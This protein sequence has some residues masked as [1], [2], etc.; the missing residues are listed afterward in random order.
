MNKISRN[1]A[2]FIGL[3]LALFGYL[4]IVVGQNISFL[5][6][7]FTEQNLTILGLLGIWILTTLILALLKTGERKPFA[8]IGFKTSTMKEIIL[9][10]VIGIVLSLSVPMLTWLVSQILPAAPPDGSVTDVA[11][12][13]SWLLLLISILTAGITEEIIFRG[14]VLERLFEKTGKWW[15]AIVVSMTAFVLPHLFTWNMV[16]L[17]AVVI[18]LGLILSWLYI[19]KRNLVFNIIVHIV[20]DLPLVFIALSLS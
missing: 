14:Y 17:I 2:T 11:T 8:S 10:I 18:P 19:W 3:I 7:N 1:T 16:H 9:A 6:R 12:K 15:L 13:T 4:L 20:I 5:S